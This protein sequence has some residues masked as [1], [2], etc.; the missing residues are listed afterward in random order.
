[1]FGILLILPLVVVVASGAILRFSGIVE[2][3]ASHYLN[4]ILYW[5]VLPVLL[6]RTTQKVDVGLFSD[7][8]LL[9]AIHVPFIIA[10][11]FAWLIARFFD[12]NPKRVA[13]SVL[14]AIRSNNIFIG[15]PVVSLALGQQGLGALSIFFAIGLLGYNL[16]SITWAQICLS[17]TFTLRSILQTLR[18]IFVN[19][20][21][22]G[23]ILGVGSSMI[24]FGS[25][26]GW[27]DSGFEIIVDSASGVALIS[28]GISLE[29]NNLVKALWNTWRESLMRLFIYPALVWIAFI[30]W[31]AEPVLAKTIILVSA[32]PSAINNF[33]ISQ[34]MGM[35]TGYASESIAS[36]TIISVLTIPLWLTVLSIS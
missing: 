20:L 17:G 12:P 4:N 29:F 19:P 9:F 7:L 14:N 22:W 18:Q 13:F 21:I 8:N 1:M 32:M 27:V 24:G 15:I 30:I 26:P 25:L 5:G 36:S 11:G 16:V 23:C 6:F 10:P 34:G 28:L 33:V 2:K 35:D 31:P 3:R